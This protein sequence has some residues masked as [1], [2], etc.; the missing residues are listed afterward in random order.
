MRI[1][2]L[3]WRK[4]WILCGERLHQKK[5]PLQ[6]KLSL[7]CNFFFSVLFIAYL[8]FSFSWAIFPV[9]FLP[10]LFWTVVSIWLYWRRQ[11]IFSNCFIF[12]VDVFFGTVSPP[13][14]SSFMPVSNCHRTL[15]LL[16]VPLWSDHSYSFSN[17]IEWDTALRELFWRLKV[18]V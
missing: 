15:Q 3:L 10:L 6:H 17:S 1:M 2:F 18:K 12:L 8:H 5:K 11:G 9:L 4:K 7:I 13:T 14:S 16:T